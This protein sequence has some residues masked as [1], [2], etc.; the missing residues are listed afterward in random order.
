MS[1]VLRRPCPCPFPGTGLGHDCGP[2]PGPALE[3]PLSWPC[4]GP[5]PTPL[6]ALA[7]PPAINLP[8]L[9]LSSLHPVT[10]GL[11]CPALP[12]V[13]PCP[14]PALA[15]AWWVHSYSTGILSMAGPHSCR[16]SWARALWVCG[17]ETACDPQVRSSGHH[18]GQCPVSGGVRNRNWQLGAGSWLG[19]SFCCSCSPRSAAWVSPVIPVEWG[20]WHCGVSSTHSRPHFLAS[21]DQKERLDFGGWV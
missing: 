9:T 20:A 11:I 17:A 16:V 10:L 19:L 15:G 3:L 13:W 12:S 21:L 7:L 1:L 18:G 5:I 14:D 6:L 4:P 2:N 8:W